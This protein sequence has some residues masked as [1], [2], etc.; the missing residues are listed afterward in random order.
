MP[1]DTYFS[2]SV[3]IKQFFHFFFLSNAV[4]TDVGKINTL[5]TV[6]F[7]KHGPIR[8]PN[9]ACTKCDRTATLCKRWKRNVYYCWYLFEMGPISLKIGIGSD[10]DLPHQFGDILLWKQGE[11][12]LELAPCGRRASLAVPV[13]LRRTTPPSEGSIWRC[14]T[15]KMTRSS[16]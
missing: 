15:W 12:K 1:R 13:M 10:F 2:F 6:Y 5:W 4:A 8:A 16:C 7:L 3:S 14:F 9:L 11:T